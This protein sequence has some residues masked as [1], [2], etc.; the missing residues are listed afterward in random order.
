MKCGVVVVIVFTGI[1][2]DVLEN[3]RVV[4]V[5]VVVL[6]EGTLVV[7]VKSVVDSVLLS[8]EVVDFAEATVV[9]VVVEFWSVEPFTSN[10]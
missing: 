9:L 1:V 6:L 2:E 10:A 3:H 4:L 7:V 8:M 5:L